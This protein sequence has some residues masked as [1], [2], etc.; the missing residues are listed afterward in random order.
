MSNLNDTTNQNRGRKG[1]TLAE[2]AFT[3]PILL[4]MMFG[5]IEFGRFFQS[6]VTVQNA[7]RSA[8]RY[9]STGLYDEQRYPLNT[10][11]ADEKTGLVP[12]MEADQRG[13]KTTIFPNGGTEGV[14]VY[15]SPATTG[16]TG[17]EALF[18]TMYDG[19]DCDPSDVEVSQEQR[20]DLARL[21]SIME[22]ARRGAAGIPVSEINIGIPADPAVRDIAANWNSFSYFRPWKTPNAAAVPADPAFQRNWF[23][24]LICSPD[25]RF[26]YVEGVRDEADASTA[27]F[28]NAANQ[29]FVLYI[30]GMSQVPI[31]TSTGNPISAPPVPTCFLNEVIRPVGAN[32]SK[33]LSNA[34]RAWMD[35]GGPG[36]TVVIVISF[37]HPLITPLPLLP[38]YLPITARRSAVVE[39]YRPANP[40]KAL[41]GAPPALGG[42]G[43][44]PTDT[45]THTATAT[46]QIT[47]TRT[48]TSAP[49]ASATKPPVFS[50]DLL[51][52]RDLFI[53]GRDVFVDIQNNNL[54][55]QT[56]I[57]RVI[58][59][60]PRLTD[61]PSMKVDMMS[62]DGAVF[63][64]GT[65]TSSPTDTNTSPGLFGEGTRTLDIESTGTMAISFTEG[66][67]DWSVAGVSRFDFDVRVSFRSLDNVNCD[68]SFDPGNPTVT[69]TR[70]A[71]QPTPTPTFTPDCASSN[72]EVRFIGFEP[73][74]IVRLEVRSNRSIVSTLTSFSVAWRKVGSINLRRITAVAAPGQPGSV[75]IWEHPNGAEDATPPTTSGE[76][77]AGAFSTNY[78]FDPRSASG[79]STTPL[80]L[81]FDGTSAPLSDIGIG[82]A[83][84]NG[85]WFELSCG[86]PGGGGS[87]GGV[88]SIGRINLAEAPTAPP[89]ATRGPTNTPAPTR[90]PA[91]PLP[92]ATPSRTPPASVT[93]LP[94]TPSRTPVPTNTPVPPTRPGGGNIGC[95]DNC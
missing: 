39:S 32:A 19:R 92:T 33:W 74:G 45:P 59:T 16:E 73:F 57:T 34:G 52:V 5:I 48:P 35:P 20:K 79:P 85:T 41:V 62:L 76:G 44:V 18:A 27:Y 86:N 8:A 37:N 38:N 69:P 28:R 9:A 83:D 58:I 30:P 42:P 54:A 13:N 2:F 75:T 68:E 78:R 63:W 49:T 60:W 84:F 40:L 7:A 3:L 95:T 82:R 53:A 12:C 29:R 71:N 15:T 11:G 24:V 90:T 67:A 88:G 89:T 31:L 56:I 46:R 23:N 94:P 93:P 72:I 4:I 36:N 43:A 77:G 14:Q 80:L 26:D 55:A 51:E 61:Y 6:W 22:V 21:L 81:D 10:T 65:G 64:D 17:K 66:P 87:G 1:Q 91:P 25:R 70:P 50:C 47:A